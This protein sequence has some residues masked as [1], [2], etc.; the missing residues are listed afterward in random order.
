MA[1]SPSIIFRKA[2]DFEVLKTHLKHCNM[3]ILMKF[4]ELGLHKLYGLIHN[5]SD[6][7]TLLCV[8]VYGTPSP[9]TTRHPV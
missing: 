7:Y 6:I 9:C 4:Y 5:T 8:K 1:G 2:A 3:L